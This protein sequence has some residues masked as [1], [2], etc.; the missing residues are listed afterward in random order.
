MGLILSG[1]K[2]SQGC[3]RKHVKNN[4]LFIQTSDNLACESVSGM[5]FIETKF[6][7]FWVINNKNIPL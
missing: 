5:Q 7:G 1:L 4:F 3:S 6:P 2:F